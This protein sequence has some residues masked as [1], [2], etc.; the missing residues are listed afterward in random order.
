MTLFEG[1]HVKAKLSELL[2]RIPGAPSEQWPQGERC[3]LAFSHGSTSVG[4]HVPVG[5]DRQRPHKRDELYIIRNGTG[6]LIVEGGSHPFEPGHIFFVGSGQE[7]KFEDFS[8]DF[9]TWVD[10]RGPPGGGLPT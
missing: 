9:S 5:P 7:Q 4:L 2:S 8:S 6:R 10:F 1:E 3:A